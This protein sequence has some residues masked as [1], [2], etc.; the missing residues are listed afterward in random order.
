MDSEDK[1]REKPTSDRFKGSGLDSKELEWNKQIQKKIDMAASKAS[2]SSF[3]KYEKELSDKNNYF[4]ISKMPEVN[5]RDTQLMNSKMNSKFKSNATY[6]NDENNTYC[7]KCPS[8][9]NY[10]PHKNKKEQIKDKYSYPIVTNATYGWL[11]SYDNLG[12]NHNLDS[13]TKSFYNQGH[14]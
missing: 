6:E 1:P 4:A 14:L 2:S 3:Q 5:E 9:K 8:T 7:Q 13:T 12:D 11:P 10:C